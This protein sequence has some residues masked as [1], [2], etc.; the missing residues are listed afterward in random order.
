M[1]RIVKNTVVTINYTVTDPDGGMID[2]GHE[3][4]VYLHGGYENIFMPVETALEGKA[5]GE[6]MTVKLQPGAAFGEY[7]PDLVQIVPVDELPEPLKIG[8]MIEGTPEGGEG[9]EPVFFTIT[10]IADGKA[11]LDA[12]HPWPAWRWCSPA[13]LRRC[14]RPV[15]K[16]SQL[17]TRCSDK[18]CLICQVALTKIVNTRCSPM[19][20]HCNF[21]YLSRQL[22][23]ACFVLEFVTKQRGTR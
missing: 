21:N 3:P 5:I 13:R 1:N 10:G 17:A 23:R 15:V 6:S 9:D 7:D 14:A 18:R 4:I 19:R 8:M 11:V 22:G 2:D 16:R 12:N 20:I